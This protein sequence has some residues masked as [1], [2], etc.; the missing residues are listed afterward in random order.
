[1][2]RKPTV[3]VKSKSN[4]HLEKHFK[5][6]TLQSLLDGKEKPE[7]VEGIIIS[8]FFNPVVEFRT[9]LL[10]RMSRLKIV[11]PLGVGIDFMED[12]LLDYCRQKSIVVALNTGE[13]HMC[14]AVADFAIGLMLSCGRAIHSGAEYLKQAK[15]CSASE[16][17]PYK[18]QLQTQTLSITGKCIGII[19]LGRIGLEIA[20]RAYHGFAMKIVYVSRNRKS[21]DLEQSVGAE[22]YQDL[23]A[24][25]PVCDYVV[26]A[27]DSNQHTRQLLG[28][29]EF[30]TMKSSAIVIN[31][32]RGDIIDTDALT[33]ALKAKTIAGAGLDVTD[34]EP[35]P[36][37]HPLLDMANVTVTPH[38]AW[39][40][41]EVSE[42]LQ[43]SQCRNLTDVLVHGKQPRSQVTN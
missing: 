25:L 23:K 37:D 39:C 6:I 4:V 17:I 27:C 7:E 34:P 26:I 2:E 41:G 15:A 43:R 11:T 13:E 36:A 42:E 19:G 16:W 35:L 8:K 22:F 18:T 28:A 21:E 12:Y 33:V 38:I 5:V 9:E 1:M 24:M 29:A 20:K 3:L 40:L 30:S 31:I 32:A 10:P 14:K